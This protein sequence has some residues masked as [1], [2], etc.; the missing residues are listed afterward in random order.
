MILFPNYQDDIESYRACAAFWYDVFRKALLASD[1]VLPDW[2][3]GWSDG[4]GRFR[5][6]DGTQYDPV[7]FAKKF[8]GV[9]PILWKISP[10]SERAVRLTHVLLGE[11]STD[12][13]LEA[14]MDA[15]EWMQ[16][17]NLDVLSFFTRPSE[18][19]VT[20]IKMMMSTWVLRS[21]SLDDM[22]ALTD[23]LYREGKTI[24]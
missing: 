16:Y 1:D 5:T 20:L 8:G 17:D 15:H 23:R 9:S 19:E 24:R 3:N 14:K 7:T 4:E 18:N 21:T 11:N 6:G 13:F 12:P 22:R 2:S 10:S